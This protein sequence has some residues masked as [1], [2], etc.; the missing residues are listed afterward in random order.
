MKKTFLLLIGVITICFGEAMAQSVTV[1]AS[2]DS[3]QI[4]IGDHAKVK[5]QVSV[6]AD[7]RA[8]LPIYKDT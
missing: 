8:F 6:D 3:L 4:L 1:D 7:K 5:L 2:I